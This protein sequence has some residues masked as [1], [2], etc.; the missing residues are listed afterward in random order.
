M[1]IWG[2]T[3]TTNNVVYLIEDRHKS[4]I[5]RIL[6]LK[7]QDVPDNHVFIL[8]YFP[9]IAAW[10]YNMKIIVILIVLGF[11]RA[12]KDGE[13][14]IPLVSYEIFVPEIQVY[15]VVSTIYQVQDE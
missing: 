11:V 6:M 14:E 1:R 4:D 7:T 15:N 12:V 10:S 3:N 5:D 2:E 8:W 13:R 9:F